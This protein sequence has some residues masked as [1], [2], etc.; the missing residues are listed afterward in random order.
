M[1]FTFLSAAGVTLFTRSDAETAHWVQEEM[2][3]N[4]TFPFVDGKVIERGQRL[5]FRDPATDKIE[6]FE[7]RSVSSIEPDHYQQIS[8][9][10][11]C[12]SG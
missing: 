2:T 4:A 1:E 3:V 11:I 5:A 7:V 9:E 6:V 10:A 8:A 12:L